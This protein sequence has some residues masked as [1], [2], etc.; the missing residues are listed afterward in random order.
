M[1]ILHKLWKLGWPVVWLAMAGPGVAELRLTTDPVKWIDPDSR[2]IREPKEL[3]E[4]LIW[5]IVDHTFFYEVG[6]LLDLGWT[7]RRAGNI[8]NV[9]P[10]RQADNVN[11]LDEVPN[12]SWYT[13][14]HFLK[15]LTAED[16][17]AGAGIAQPDTSG[18]WEIVSGKFE[19]LAP[20]FTIRDAKDETFFLKFDASGNEGLATTAEVVSTKI[21]YAAGYNV[22]QNSVVFFYPN[23]LKIGPE[24]EV[25]DGA[26]G[27]RA[28]QDRDLQEILDFIN[29]QPDGRIRC[30][31]SKLLDGTPVGVF[32]FHDRRK[33]DP[34]DRVDHQHR[35]ELRGLRVISSWIN[36]VD[37]RAAN[38]L[39]MYVTGGQ[40]IKH[41]LI[42]MGAT[43]GSSTVTPRTPKSGHEYF[44]DV[45]YIVPSIV[46]MGLYR[47]VWEEPLPMK[48][49]A[50]GYLESEVFDTARWVTN[51]P[52]PA[53]QRCTDRD[54]YWGAKIVMA[55]SDA[56]LEAIVKSGQLPDPG[57]EAELIRLLKA[58][59]DKVGR[60]WFKRI[61]T[62]DRF[63]TDRKGLHFED[64]A[65]TGGLVSKGQ[66]R[67]RYRLLDH[68]G[69]AIGVAQRIETEGSISVSE[70][71][72]SGQ[73]YGF[74]IRALRPGWA[75]K[76]VRVYF[77]VR[78]PGRY[79]VVRVDREE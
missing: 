3:E 18:T 8:L 64:L 4:N 70:D 65:V 47:R 5:D 71:L 67:Y 44:V 29:K 16:L 20:G 52:N 38:T 51:Y 14:R 60:Y 23:R 41:Y 28:M 27:K 62:L 30:V 13:N 66:T 74:E 43:L 68:R 25:S 42:D 72:R 39:D 32:N 48:Y 7:A 35:R 11:A 78:E 49:P 63:W 9:A 6:K 33:D 24:A 22:P 59:R 75:D 26:G 54:G 69:R 79:Q 53:F 58:R 73:F 17:A 76:Y 15:R 34:N 19:G 31:A 37:R 2:S 12:S 46:G 21:L 1:P 56:D 40:Y 50:I 77:Y 36:D 10:P 45:R 57:A 61:N 55:F